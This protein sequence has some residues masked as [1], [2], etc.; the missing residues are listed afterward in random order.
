MV[1]LPDPRRIA[2]QVEHE[3]RER[4]RQ[5][6]TDFVKAMITGGVDLSPEEMID[7]AFLVVERI[8][9]RI[10]GEEKQSDIIYSVHDGH[11]PEVF[12]E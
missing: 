7:A 11:V 8:N 3:G 1:R 5:E 6:V 10:Y 9:D 2:L 12:D 4:K